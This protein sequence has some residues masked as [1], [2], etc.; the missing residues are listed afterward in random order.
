[1]AG[2]IGFATSAPVFV[3]VLR[4][5]GAPLPLPSP[6]LSPPLSR[7]RARASAR[8]RRRYLT[9]NHWPMLR[10]GQQRRRQQQPASC[11]GQS[12]GRKLVDNFRRRGR[13]QIRGAPIVE[14]AAE[15]TSADAGR[16]FG[17]SRSDSGGGGAEW[18]AQLRLLSQPASSLKMT[19]S[20]G[21]RRARRGQSDSGQLFGGRRAAILCRPRRAML[22]VLSGLFGEP[23][24][25]CRFKSWSGFL[26]GAIVC[27][28][29][30]RRQSFLPELGQPGRLMIHPERPSSAQFKV[31]WGGQSR[32]PAACWMI[33]GR[34]RQ[35][36]KWPLKRAPAARS[37]STFEPILV[38]SCLVSSRLNS[39]R[40]V[41]SCRFRAS[42][43]QFGHCFPLAGAARLT[44]CRTEAAPPC[45][46]GADERQ[47]GSAT[48]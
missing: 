41:L 34:R 3:F 33:S 8:A 32:P 27:F 42:P 39:T 1:M 18:G 17:P 9:S 14:L 11:R 22:G 7:K 20:S 12:S 13:A 38:L 36:A 48:Q 40:L 5:H 15:L 31:I 2:Q 45:E 46:C 16:K 47:T 26:R 24:I 4:V 43:S 10:Q 35:P 29:F 19:P 21:S 44:V 23:N 25:M 6:P 37:W 30:G 28:Q